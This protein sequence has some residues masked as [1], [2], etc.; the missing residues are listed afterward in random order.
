MTKKEMLK[1]L[2][3]MELATIDHV[4]ES[5]VIKRIQMI[6]ICLGSIIRGEKPFNFP[7]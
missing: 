5:C 6:E 2:L 4:D 1:K 7:A 3:E